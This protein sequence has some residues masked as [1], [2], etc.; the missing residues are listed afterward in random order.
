MP[1]RQDFINGDAAALALTALFIAACL[2]LAWLER[3]ADR[4]GRPRPERRSR[5]RTRARRAVAK[6][7]KLLPRGRA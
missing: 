2:V 7:A 3:R 6:V 5:A 1:T 4:D